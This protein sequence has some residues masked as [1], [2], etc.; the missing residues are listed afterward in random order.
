DRDFNPTSR[1]ASKIN[2]LPALPQPVVQRANT[3]FSTWAGRTTPPPEI[4]L[5]N[6]AT[7]M[8]E[9]PFDKRQGYV[10]LNAGNYA[11]VDGAAGYRF[12]D[13]GRSTLGLNLL[14]NSTN[15][16]V[17]YAQENSNPKSNKLY[18]MDNFGQLR[19]NQLFDALHLNMHV[20]Y[21]HSMFNYYGNT[22]SEDR[23]FE[24]E[25]QRLGV[26]NANIGFNSRRNVQRLGYRGSVDL[27]N[28]HTK[29]GDSLSQSGIR[30]NEI[31]AGLGLFQPFDAGNGNSIIGVDGRFFTTTYSD[32]ISNYSQITAAPY[33]AFLG[34]RF[35]AQLGADVQFQFIDGNK[36]RVV[37][38][39]DVNLR[40]SNHSSLYAK[41][42]GGFNPNTFVNVMNESRY[43]T[44]MA[45]AT[46]KPSFTVVDL[47]AGVKIG[48]LSGFRFDVFGGFRQTDDEYFLVGI[49]SL[50]PIFGNLSHSHIGGMIQ[51]NIWAPLDLSLRAKNNFYTVKE[52]FDGS[53]AYNK[54]GLETDIRATFEATGALRFTLNYYFAGDRWTYFSGGNVK[55][56]NINDLNFGA[57]YRITDFLSVNLKAN[58]LLLQKY[59]IW[60]GFPAQGFNAMGG[61]T[62]KF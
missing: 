12:I 34:D 25:N 33:I 20:S 36:V 53:K 58:N 22:F 3:N 50:A 14:H 62:F 18:L 37:P 48:E 46:M 27:K 23:W 5:P 26:F 31:D 45:A 51:T 38:N 19:F 61:F 47:E 41:V 2:S 6:P 15:G 43:V 55:M 24:N 54:P 52:M 59:D 30:G 10:S 39:V 60:Y 1:A 49:E 17:N 8:T 42:H 16:N 13:N 35:T 44:P 29:F 21:L 4:A 11:N 56:N 9:I 57:T 7:A 32:T 40:L 28:F